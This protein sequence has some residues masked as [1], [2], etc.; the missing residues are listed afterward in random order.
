MEQERT[1]FLLLPLTAVG[2]TIQLSTSRPT[3]LGR[4]TPSQQLENLHISREQV[5]LEVKRDI[6]GQ[7]LIQMTCVSV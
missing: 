5:V 3:A 2:E 7:Y 6:S 4:K 1:R